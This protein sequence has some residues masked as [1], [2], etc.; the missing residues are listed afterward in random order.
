VS[1]AEGRRW[2]SRVSHRALDQRG[3]SDRG[4]GGKLVANGFEK[5]SPAD[6]RPSLIRSKTHRKRTPTFS[7]L[8][9][10]T[11]PRKTCKTGIPGKSPG[12]AFR[13]FYLKKSV[14]EAVGLFEKNR[15]NEFADLGLTTSPRPLRGRGAPRAGRAT[16]SRNTARRRA[17]KPQ[18]PVQ[19]PA[20][21][22]RCVRP[23][24]GSA[25]HCIA[26]HAVVR[27]GPRR[28]PAPP[29]PALV[30]RPQHPED[31][32]AQAREHGHSSGEGKHPPALPVPLRPREQK[33]APDQTV[34]HP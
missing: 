15:Q 14:S 5:R 25:V 19:M 4:T 18:R 31:A 34:R 7:T 8:P 27:G 10:Y 21:R 3:I 26:S 16:A 32:E 24:P 17:S 20:A 22:A 23:G 11:F 1:K 30:E 29:L 28:G 2:R 12:M 9:F 33:K 6:C 13:R